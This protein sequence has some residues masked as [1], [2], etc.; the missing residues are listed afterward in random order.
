MALVAV[1][2]V[3]KRWGSMCG[4]GIS[5]MACARRTS[6]LN[7]FELISLPML[8]L[9]VWHTACKLVFGK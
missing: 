8:V 4:K 1:R 2:N 5:K 9:W 7:C 6:C 3:R